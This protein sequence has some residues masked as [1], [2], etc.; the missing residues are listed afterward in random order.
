MPT[1]TVIDTV[2]GILNKYKF[3]MFVLKHNVILYAWLYSA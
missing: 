2:K 3:C 1:N